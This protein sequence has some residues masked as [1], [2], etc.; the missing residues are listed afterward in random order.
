MSTFAAELAAADQAETRA[1]KNLDDALR[2]VTPVTAEL[3]ELFLTRP[4]EYANC[5]RKM[6]DI[7]DTI[8]ALRTALA[9]A[10]AA[11]DP[12]RAR[13]CAKCLGTGLYTAPTT[14]LQHGKPVCFRCGGTAEEPRLRA[15]A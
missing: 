11:A 15:T 10:T 8:P 7:L 6:A 14:H 1:R 3:H 5:L 12:L 13:A 2:H 4:A 9:D